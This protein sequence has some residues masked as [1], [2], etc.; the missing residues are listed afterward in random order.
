MRNQFTTTSKEA[1]AI[2]FYFFITVHNYSCR[3][4]VNIKPC[5]MNEMSKL[6]DFAKSTLKSVETSKVKGGTGTTDVTIT[7]I[8]IEDD[9][10]E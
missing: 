1:V 4:I 9:Y 5:I 10:E 3:Y 7:S 2:V 8:I 6:N